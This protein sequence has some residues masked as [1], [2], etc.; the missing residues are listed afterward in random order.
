MA[1]PFPAA[2]RDTNSRPLHIS[3]P[4]ELVNQVWEVAYRKR[5]H[6][7]L[8]RDFIEAGMQK[9]AAEDQDAAVSGAWARMT[10]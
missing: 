7:H 4:E 9:P 5:R 8:W 1:N 3:L 10:T 6:T 2:N